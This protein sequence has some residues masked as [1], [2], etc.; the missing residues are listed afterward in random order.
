MKEK[1]FGFYD[2]DITVRIVDDSDCI[3]RV[4]TE[5]GYIIELRSIMEDWQ[6]V[7]EVYHLFFGV[8]AMIHADDYMVYFL[9]LSDEPYAYSFH[10]LYREVKKA[11]EELTTYTE[12]NP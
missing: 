11:H 1:K 7:H 6:I 12:D 5:G 4:R 8:M 9:N 3:G 2:I 10:Y